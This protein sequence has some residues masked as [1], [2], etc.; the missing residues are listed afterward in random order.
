MSTEVEICNT[1][2]SYIGI[3]KI[4][5]SLS[6]D[7]IEAKACNRVYNNARDFVLRTHPWK[8]ATRTIDLADLGT[9]PADWGYRYAYPS[10]CIQIQEI[11][12][13]N[14]DV[15]PATP[16]EVALS[17]DKSAKVILCDKPQ[18][19]LKYT[20]IV[21]NSGLFDIMFADALS[22]RIAFLIWTLT[23]SR[24]VQQSAMDGFNQSINMAWAANSNEQERI[25]QRMPEHIKA[26]G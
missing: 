25:F 19:A 9:P 11:L 12:S 22:W 26:R 21:T 14:K 16:Y 5:S 15:D 10:D 20:V 23:G 2:L 4:I 8:F 18:A 6:E 24:K 7:S 17:E 1:A 3:D 13:V